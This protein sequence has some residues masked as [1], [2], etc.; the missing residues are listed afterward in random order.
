LHHDTCPHVVVHPEALVL[1]QITVEGDWLT[2]NV[3]MVERPGTPGFA[4]SQH[5]PSV[6]THTS[7][8]PSY[9]RFPLSTI[10]STS[11]SF[12]SSSEAASTTTE[13]VLE[14]LTMYVRIR[15]S[16]VNSHTRCARG[17]VRGRR[18]GGQT[19]SVRG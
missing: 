8:S 12:A 10:K 17:A 19:S 2:S 9:S 15:F 18:Y 4:D 16:V 7:T 14:Y 6:T 11:V 1:R 13:Y 5:A 3:R